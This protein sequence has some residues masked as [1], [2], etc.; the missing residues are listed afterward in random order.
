MNS[1]RFKIISLFE[2]TRET[3][4]IVYFALCKYNLGFGGPPSPEESS[5]EVEEQEDIQIYN[6]FWSSPKNF[7]FIANWSDQLFVPII[8]NRSFPSLQHFP[9]GMDTLKV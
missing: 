9:L 5:I 4:V 3:R 6:M 2:W 7:E 1:D 8:H